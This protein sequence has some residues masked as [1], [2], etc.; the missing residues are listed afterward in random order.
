MNPVAEASG[1]SS[2]CANAGRNTT[3]QNMSVPN[4]TATPRI[5]TTAAIRAESAIGHL[6]ASIGFIAM[7]DHGPGS[8]NSVAMVS[9]GA[10][11]QGWPR[12]VAPVSAA[13][14]GG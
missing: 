10:I 1:P 9:S 6:L 7:L 11:F 14:G 5:A 3:A 13:P 12:T 4:S 2:R 8:G